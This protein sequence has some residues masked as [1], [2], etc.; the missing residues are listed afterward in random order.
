MDGELYES[1][2][3]PE[4]AHTPAGSGAYFPP[5]IALLHVTRGGADA[6][7]LQLRRNWE[8]YPAS[9]KEQLVL[10]DVINVL[11][12]SE[13]ALYQVEPGT[14]EV[15]RSDIVDASKL[16]GEEATVVRNGRCAVHGGG[17]DSGAGSD[18]AADTG[19][20]A[21]ERARVRGAEPL[22]GAERAAAG[23]A[24]P[25]RAVRRVAAE[26]GHGAAE[27]QA[28]R[29]AGH[30]H[31]RGPGDAHGHRSDHGGAAD[32]QAGGGLPAV[33]DGGRPAG[34]D[35]PAD[36]A[37]D[38]RLL[39]PDGP[40]GQLRGAVRPVP[41]VLRG[42]QGGD[43]GGVWDRLDPGAGGHQGR[44]ADGAG[45]GQL[46]A[47]PGA[48]GRAD[49]AGS[50]AAAVH[51]AGGAQGG[52]CGD[53]PGGVGR[54]DE[55]HRDGV[56]A[57]G[58]AGVGAPVLLAGA[59]G[60]RG[61]PAG[62]PG[63]PPAAG[64]GHAELPG[65]G[66]AVVAPGGR[67]PAPVHAGARGG[68]RAGAER[69]E[70]RGRLAAGA[71]VPP[72]GVAAAHILQRRGP[73]QVPGGL[74]VPAAAQADGARAGAHLADAHEVEAAAAG[75]QRA[76]AAQLHLRQHRAHALLLPQPGL[77]VHHRGD[78]AELH[79]AAA[80]LRE[81][82]EGRAGAAVLQL[83][84]GAAPAVRGAGGGAVPARG[85]GGGAVRGPRA[86]ALRRVRDAGAGVPGA[87]RDGGGG[88]PRVAG[89]GG[90]AGGAVHGRAAAQPGVHRDGGHG[91]AAVRRAPA[92]A[93]GRARGG[94]GAAPEQL[95]VPAQVQRVF[96]VKLVY[97][98]ALVV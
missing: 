5:L 57:D 69:A 44:G 71:A 6:L 79:A 53:A 9:V 70:R 26:G 52:R 81:P 11:C 80:G 3:E 82:P 56:R 65:G 16:E 32:Q 74:P 95:A 73:G 51:L 47:D 36:E 29:A 98:S 21:G 7:E 13:G 96:H 42:A 8:S 64:G 90:G 37:G 93:G 58:A 84:R 89:G 41:R 87:A 77:P 4:Y 59:R 88:A 14:Y 2:V 76:A 40:V 31:V 68:E 33:R 61:Q 72:G 15:R 92:G 54:A 30:Q 50:A 67:A 27:V 39:Q 86:V 34:A 62:R 38:G 46:R 78:G 49:G 48:V 66:G 1:C 22:R 94:G 60:P 43:E 20:R 63:R 10:E 97:S 85:R 55:A 45:D 91:V 19:L 83:P 24:E 75:A 23:A 18:A 25:D 28:V 12:G 17:G 35:E